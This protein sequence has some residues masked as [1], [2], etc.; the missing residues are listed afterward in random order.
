LFYGYDHGQ[1]SYLG[2]SVDEE[3]QRTSALAVLINTDHYDEARWT[4]GFRLGVNLNNA[5][6]KYVYQ[7]F[8]LTLAF[9]AGSHSLF[10]EVL[11]K[12]PLLTSHRPLGVIFSVVMG[13]VTSTFE[14]VIAFFARPLLRLFRMFADLWIIVSHIVAGS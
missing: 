1:K 3:R 13:I 5:I 12:G 10:F 4:K 11:H 2:L 7:I 6:Y 8:F 9:T 14:F